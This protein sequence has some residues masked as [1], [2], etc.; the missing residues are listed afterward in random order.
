VAIDPRCAASQLAVLDRTEAA[1]EEPGLPDLFADYLTGRVPAGAVADDILTTFS[2]LLAD[3]GREDPGEF[4]EEA[5]LRSV[6]GEEL[7]HQPP[8]G[9]LLIPAQASRQ[10]TGQD[11]RRQS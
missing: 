7:G 6:L 8:A 1:G 5:L 10:D 2:A 9:G 3:I 4:R 11:A